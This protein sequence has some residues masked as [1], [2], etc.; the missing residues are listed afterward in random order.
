MP[1][2]AMVERGL[3]ES[4]VLGISDVVTGAGEIVQTSPYLTIL[5]V[6][7]VGYLLIRRR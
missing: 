4:A 2:Q 6:L 3:L 5:L 7:V 1:A